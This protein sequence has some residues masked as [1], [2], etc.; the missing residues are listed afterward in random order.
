MKLSL[1]IIKSKSDLKHYYS[2]EHYY[3]E[4]DYFAFTPLCPS[5][6]NDA[7]RIYCEFLPLITGNIRSNSEQLLGFKI[8]K[9]LTPEHYHCMIEIIKE[10]ERKKG[11]SKQ[12]SSHMKGIIFPEIKYLTKIAIPDNTAIECE[13]KEFIPLHNNKLISTEEWELIKT[14]KIQCKSRIIHDHFQI[15]DGHGYIKSY[16]IA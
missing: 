11:F 16:K 14:L 4:K 15:P 9:K 13:P 10:T 2:S 8:W 12:L 7:L 5:H 1:Y 3:M 6:L